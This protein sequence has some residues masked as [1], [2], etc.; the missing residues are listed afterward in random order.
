MH[1]KKGPLADL[2]SQ[3]ARLR[4]WPA[5]REDGAIAGILPVKVS[6]SLPCSVRQDMVHL[7]QLIH[8]FIAN[9]AR[10]AQIRDWAED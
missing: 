8:L 10:L 2:L 7:H 3:V 9:G 5:A 4:F 1:C 6:S